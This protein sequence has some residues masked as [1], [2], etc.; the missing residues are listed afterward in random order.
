MRNIKV[1][2]LGHSGVGKSSIF[3]RLMRDQYTAMQEST[4]GAA[5]N[6]VFVVEDVDGNLSLAQTASA[7]ASQE[8]DA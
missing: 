3:S 8:T 7:A 5:Y 6:A 2:M 1:V 4:I